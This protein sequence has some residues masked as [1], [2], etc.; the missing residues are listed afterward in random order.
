MPPDG[1]PAAGGINPGPLD[2]AWREKE[3]NTPTA[4]PGQETNDLNTPS[5][6]PRCLQRATSI[7][8]DSAPSWAT[9]RRARAEGRPQVSR[10]GNTGKA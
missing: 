1:C 9:L 10:A 3:L 5:T 7:R 8:N 4:G 2:R 6:G